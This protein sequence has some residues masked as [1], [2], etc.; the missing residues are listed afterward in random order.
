MA[1]PPST[2]PLSTVLEA[3]KAD[4]DLTDEQ[5][6]ALPSL[7]EVDLVRQN[8]SELI[9]HTEPTN[10]RYHRFKLYIGE[11]QNEPWHLYLFRAGNRK[12]YQLEITS[13]DLDNG[14]H[15]EPYDARYFGTVSDLAYPFN[16]FLCAARFIAVVKWYFLLGFRAGTFDE[17]PG[18][19]I[20]TS[21]RRDLQGACEE[22]IA[23]L[24]RELRMQQRDGESRFGG[25][26]R[27]KGD[28]RRKHI[29]TIT[30]A[31]EL[32]KATAS[33]AKLET[34]TNRRTQRP[35]PVENPLPT[36]G[37][38]GNNE[39]QE[40]KPRQVSGHGKSHSASTTPLP[41]EREVD[42]QSLTPMD[43]RQPRPSRNSTSYGSSSPPLFPRGY[44]QATRDR[45]RSQSPQRFQPRTGLQQREGTQPAGSLVK[46]RARDTTRRE[47]SRDDGEAAR[48]TV[49]FKEARSVTAGV[50]PRQ[51]I[52]REYAIGVDGRVALGSSANDM[53]SPDRTD[54]RRRTVVEAQEFLF[55][56][57]EQDEDENED[58]TRRSANTERA[59]REDEWMQ[60][61][62]QKVETS[63]RMRII[64]DE[65][66]IE[67]RLA[68]FDKI[69][70]A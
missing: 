49:R 51:K 55:S 12:Q 56:K 23:A 21:W 64:E 2:P 70:Y 44:G 13:V 31:N 7:D 1:T 17:D 65:M 68:V 50:Q 3:L 43:A 26:S 54:A 57:D 28:E 58:S 48:K 11:N 53:E 67:E 39:I 40:R 63:R 66:G 16:S 6:A 22:L 41:N 37:F 32:Q 45:R 27:A 47:R 15:H 38:D 52:E 36:T 60:L 8:D 35:A 62:R 5:F 34:K 10:F 29:E 4:F 59:S 9:E 19:L 14:S 33:A 25:E 42:H 24:K 30:P 20:T 69:K 46:S 61:Y 18:F